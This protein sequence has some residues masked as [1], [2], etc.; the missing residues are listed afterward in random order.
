MEEKLVKAAVTNV[1]LSGFCS[2][3]FFWDPYS[4]VISFDITSWLVY[5]WI[6]R[7]YSRLRDRR[8]N[9]PGET[10]WHT[11]YPKRDY[12]VELI[13]APTDHSSCWE[14][15]LWSI[16]GKARILVNLLRTQFA[17]CTSFEKKRDNCH[18][19]SCAYNKRLHVVWSWSDTAGL[20]YF[21]VIATTIIFVIIGR[22]ASRKKKPHVWFRVW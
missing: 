21:I 15:P 19:S 22:G 20:I 2:A 4:C 9:Q 8:L 10:E 17:E 5:T 16:D 14:D 6:A 7:V 13:L 11:N 12:V 18:D 1:K 3:A